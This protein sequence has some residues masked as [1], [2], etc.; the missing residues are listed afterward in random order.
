[1]DQLAQSAPRDVQ[2]FVDFFIG[3]INMLIPLLL[4]LSLFMFFRGL[5]VFMARAGAE[6]DHEKGKHLIIW[7]LITLF[8]MLSIYGILNFLKADF[9]FSNPFHAVLP[10]LPTQ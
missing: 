10:L 2:G 3:I 9:G 8:V 7:G 6:K 4:A 1:M 5:V